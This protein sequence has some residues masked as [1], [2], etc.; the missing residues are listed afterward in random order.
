MPTIKHSIRLLLLASL[1]TSSFVYAH[2]SFTMVHRDRAMLIEG[3]VSDWHFN[4]PHAWLYIEAP[5]ENGDMIRWGVEGGAPVHIIR[6]GVKGDTFSPGEKVKIVM[7]PLKD[8]RPAGGVCFVEKQS[9]EIIAFN[10]GSCS[11]PMVRKLWEE[12]GWLANGTHGD[13]H[14]NDE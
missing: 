10:D 2:H 13:V 3:I 8:G 14:M 1:L 12:N 5:D 6:M 11:A 4:S 7:T 9:G